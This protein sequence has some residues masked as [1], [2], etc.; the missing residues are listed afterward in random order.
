[1]DTKWEVSQVVG[2]VYDRAQSRTAPS[3]AV[4]DRAYKQ[5]KGLSYSGFSES[6]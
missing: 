6:G 2:A 1:M 5:T 4:I 3:R